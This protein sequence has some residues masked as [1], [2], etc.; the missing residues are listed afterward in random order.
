M[1]RHRR[2]GFTLIDMKRLSFWFLIV[3]GKYKVID[4][5]SWFSYNSDGNVK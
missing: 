2:K 5:P 1:T 3:N 4:M